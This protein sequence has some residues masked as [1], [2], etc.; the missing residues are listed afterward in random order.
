M[1]NKTF[2]DS[3]ASQVSLDDPS[4]ALSIKK[5]TKAKTIDNEELVEPYH[6]MRMKDTQYGTDFVLLPQFVFFPLSKWYGCNQVI[7][8]KVISFK[9]DKSR[10]L[11]HFKQ[12]KS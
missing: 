8:R 1:V 7:E 5:G 2:Y 11:S 10:S 12:K 9:H 3:W 6:K 4:G